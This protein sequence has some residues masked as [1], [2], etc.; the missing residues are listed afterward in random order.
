MLI[1][2]QPQALRGQP[3][4]LLGVADCRLR[5]NGLGQWPP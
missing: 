4:R 1:W 2:M 3:Q 5:S